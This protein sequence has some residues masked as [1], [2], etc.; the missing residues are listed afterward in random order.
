V[1][2]SPTPS[3]HTKS[4]G[5]AI[6]NLL[7]EP[8]VPAHMNTLPSCEKKTSLVSSQEYNCRSVS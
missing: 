7:S 2:T 4:L 5:T 1:V 6:N 3:M 8:S